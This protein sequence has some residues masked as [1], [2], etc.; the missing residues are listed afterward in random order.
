MASLG[1][2]RR[3][4]L[5]FGHAFVKS[6]KLNNPFWRTNKTVVLNR[7]ISQPHPTANIFNCLTLC[8]HT[9]DIHRTPP[10]SNTKGDPIAKSSMISKKRFTDMNETKKENNGPMSG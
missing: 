10:K 5:Y 7:G 8:W 3:S 6:R 1:S 4:I 2:S 9:P